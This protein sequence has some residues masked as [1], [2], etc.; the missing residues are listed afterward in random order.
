MITHQQAIQQAYAA[1]GAAI[2]GD[3][4]VVNRLFAELD[5]Q[6]G[7]ERMYDVHSGIAHAGEHLLHR[8]YQER[9]PD[10]AAGGIWTVDL[11]R[12]DAFGEEPHG[13]YALR[14]LV[15]YANHDHATCIALFRAAESLGPD[16]VAACTWQLVSD[17]AMLARS[18]LDRTDPQ[19]D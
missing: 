9:A 2:S 18:V 10:V 6:I 19:E 13:M 5:E 4:E 8:I 11:L 7:S 14:F 16:H 17:I 3:N 12:P 15:A 1:L